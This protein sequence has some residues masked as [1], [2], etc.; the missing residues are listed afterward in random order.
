ML[1]V[2]R[3]EFGLQVAQGYDQLNWSGDDCGIETAP[4][5]RLRRP[6]VKRECKTE[7]QMKLSLSRVTLGTGYHQLPLR[8]AAACDGLQDGSAAGFGSSRADGR[9]CS[10]S[11]PSAPVG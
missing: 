5:Q 9:R 4:N 8:R 2:V 3:I 10:D 6:L 1:V 7:S 11:F